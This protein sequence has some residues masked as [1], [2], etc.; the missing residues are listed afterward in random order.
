MLLNRKVFGGE[1]RTDAV[2]HHRS[3][4]RLLSPLALLPSHPS[5]TSHEPAVD[6]DSLKV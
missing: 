6:A 4:R 2:T 5:H 3:S 1:R